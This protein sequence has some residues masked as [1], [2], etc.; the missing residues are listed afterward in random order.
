MSPAK[1]LGASLVSALMETPV[2]VLLSA[3]LRPAIEETPVTRSEPGERLRS[4][5]SS[6][7]TAFLDDPLRCDRL[8]PRLDI[9]FEV[10]CR[11]SGTSTHSIPEDQPPSL[12]L[13]SFLSFHSLSFQ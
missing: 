8:R 6:L 5:L 9:R 10:N 3:E 2:A 1:L 4:E 7:P 13:P 11:G 12:P